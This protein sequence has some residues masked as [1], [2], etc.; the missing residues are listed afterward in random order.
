METT[1]TFVWR[2]WKLGFAITLALTTALVAP[3]VAIAQT[4]IDD[5]QRQN[6]VTI[7]G[8]VVRVQGDGFILN[9]GISQILVELFLSFHQLF[10]NQCLFK[11]SDCSHAHHYVN[12]CSNQTS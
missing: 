10:T 11:N 8:E 4:T 7:S 5:L 12:P 3:A 9:D 6:S 2:S 1:N